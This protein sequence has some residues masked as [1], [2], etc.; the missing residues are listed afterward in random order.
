MP[1]NKDQQAEHNT[2]MIRIRAT[3]ELK[4]AFEA[5]CLDTKQSD[6]SGGRE[7]I[8]ALVHKD[9]FQRTGKK[10]EKPDVNPRSW[11]NRR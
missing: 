4:A 6:A 8:W 1:K 2:E 9:H 10:L 7:A 3:P 5:Y 11:G